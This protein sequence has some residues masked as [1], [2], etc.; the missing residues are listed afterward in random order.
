MLS[1]LYSKNSLAVLLDLRFQNPKQIGALLICCMR[2]RCV[3]SKGPH[4]HQTH[5]TDLNRRVE[6]FFYGKIS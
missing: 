3:V 5:C 4:I 1:R 2:M 6:V